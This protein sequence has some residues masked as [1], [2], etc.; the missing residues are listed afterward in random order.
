MLNATRN[1]RAPIAVAPAVGWIRLGPRS[2]SAA[3]SLPMRSRSPSNSPLRTSGRRSRSGRV[4]ALARSEE[5]T[6]ELHSR[7]HLVCRLLLEKK[8]S[9]TREADLHVLD[10]RPQLHSH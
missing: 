3:G 4:A 7:L 5:H 1:G 9:F 10:E 2:G 8:N 6:S